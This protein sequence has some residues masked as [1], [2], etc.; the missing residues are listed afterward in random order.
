MNRFKL[1]LPYPW[2]GP[3][4]DGFAETAVRFV[5]ECPAGSNVWLIS[6]GLPPAAPDNLSKDGWRLMPSKRVTSV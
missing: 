2:H 3:V 6:R 1:R 5:E 4:L